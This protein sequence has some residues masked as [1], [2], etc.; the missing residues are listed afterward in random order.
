MKK[1]NLD[2]NIRALVVTQS[3][4][5]GL[6]GNPFA[7]ANRH[8]GMLTALLGGPKLRGIIPCVSYPGGV[9]SMVKT[10]RQIS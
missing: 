9:F 5:G 1:E 3:N 2:R 6:V 4:T 8:R 7:Q 10:Q